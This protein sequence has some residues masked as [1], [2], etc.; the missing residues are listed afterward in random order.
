MTP[1]AHIRKHP[2]ALPSTIEYLQKREAKTAQLR[3]EIAEAS[4][5]KN[6]LMAIVRDLKQLI[7]AGA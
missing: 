4:K 1:E 5:P 6:R 7:G 2:R 3:R